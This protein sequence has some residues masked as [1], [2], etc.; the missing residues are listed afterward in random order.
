MTVAN[1]A[2]NRLRRA[3][4]RPA[5]HAYVAFDGRPYHGHRMLIDAV[6][7]H[8]RR[9]DVVFEGGVSS[10]Y[11]AAELV[12]HGRRVDGVEI[13]EHAAALAREFCDTVIVADLQ[14][15]DLKD[16][17]DQYAVLLFGDTLEHL[18]APE[19]LLTRLRSRL[20]TDG[21]LIVSIPNVANWSMRLALMFGRWEYKE[22]GLLDR[23][24]L[25]FFTKKT[26][27]QLLED[28]GYVVESVVAA[29]PLPV[30]AWRPAVAAAHRIGNLWPALFA[31]TFI[32]TARR[33]DTQS[34][35]PSL[36]D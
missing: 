25:R 27:I 3:G 12:R 22:R 35:G 18:A 13:D 23:T 11:L 15:L 16:L 31:Y 17:R 5:G 34:I 33:G 9:G 36:H 14:G 19:Q 20:R 6:I 4:P 32:I 1:R 10:G 7:A 21:R 26:A 2:L 28:S 30:I 8:T 24:H 29:V